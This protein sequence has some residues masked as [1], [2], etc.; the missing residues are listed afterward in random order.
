MGSYTVYKL[1]WPSVKN[2]TRLRIYVEWA[3]ITVGCVDIDP[4]TPCMHNR[5]IRLFGGTVRRHHA[6][7]VNHTEIRCRQEALRCAQEIRDRACDE[8][9]AVEVVDHG[10]GSEAIFR[11]ECG[12]RLAS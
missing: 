6:I 10:S 7:R 9:E 5:S 8:V 1:L 2:G 12:T 11:A 3:S 4:R